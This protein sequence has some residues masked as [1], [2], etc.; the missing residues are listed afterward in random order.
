[1][2]VPNYPQEDL[3]MKSHLLE[4]IASESSVNFVHSI[5]L[6]IAAAFVATLVGL[7]CFAVL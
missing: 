2:V 4:V 7:A 6:F 5:E 1:M 3:I